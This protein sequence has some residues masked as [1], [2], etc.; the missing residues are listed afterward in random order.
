MSR[1]TNRRTWCLVFRFDCSYDSQERDH[2]AGASH[3]VSAARLPWHHSP[4]CHAHRWGP[5]QVLRPPKRKQNHDSTLAMH[6]YIYPNALQSTT[7][8]IVLAALLFCRC[9]FVCMAVTLLDFV[10]A[11]TSAAMRVGEPW[12]AVPAMRLVFIASH[13]SKVVF[14]VG[15]DC[16][17]L[18]PINLRLQ[19]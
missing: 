19:L 14:T 12:P 17:A 5:V 11:P 2:G 7:P 6:Q 15:L 4:W 16:C 9:M 13:A 1:P 8:T 18:F 3:S 10:P